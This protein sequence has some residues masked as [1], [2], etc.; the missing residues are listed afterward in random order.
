MQNEDQLEDKLEYLQS[1]F[2][3]L[4]ERQLLYEGPEAW[5]SCNLQNLE[6]R[7]WIE[8]GD[9]LADVTV[10]DWGEEVN[11]EHTAQIVRRDLLGVADFSADG[12]EVGRTEAQRNI[13]EEKNVDDEIYSVII[14]VV[15]EVGDD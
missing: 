5:D 8:E 2:I 12:V 4:S 6:E 1:S 10:G 15:I 7:N 3:L 11:D 13:E 9:D 14:C